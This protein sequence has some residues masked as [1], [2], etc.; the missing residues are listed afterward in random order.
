MLKNKFVL[1]NDEN[2]M[3]KKSK[4][5]HSEV[6]ITN[7]QDLTETSRES[8]EIITPGVDLDDGII[9]TKQNTIRQNLTKR[10]LIEGGHTF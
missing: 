7:N 5:E 2:V 3:R 10:N 4:G 9:K 8:R 6:L 1:D